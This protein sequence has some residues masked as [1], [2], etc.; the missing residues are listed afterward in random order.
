VSPGLYSFFTAEAYPSTFFP[1]PP[2]VDA[3]PDFPTC[4]SDNERETLKATNAH[5]QQNKS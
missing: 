4:N 1:F 5:D 2:E 3:V